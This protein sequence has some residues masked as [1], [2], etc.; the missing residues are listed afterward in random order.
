MRLILENENRELT[1]R[2]I[3]EDGETHG[4]ALLSD[5]GRNCL[6]NSFLLMMQLVI[7]VVRL[8]M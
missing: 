8:R 6:Q 3:R 7:V 5:T 1:M 4:P 2:D